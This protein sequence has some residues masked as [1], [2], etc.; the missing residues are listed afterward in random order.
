[1]DSPTIV[2]LTTSADVLYDHGHKSDGRA[3]IE[4]QGAADFWIGGAG[5]TSGTGWTV[6]ANV[7]Q[8]ITLRPGVQVLYG[9]AGSS[10]NVQVWPK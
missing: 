9:V 4:V 1:M 7:P 6:K 8:T 3:Q 5:V 2:A 10:I